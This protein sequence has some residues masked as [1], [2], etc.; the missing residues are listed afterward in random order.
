MKLL[1]E[2]QIRPIV[3]CSS[4]PTEKISDYLCHLLTPHLDNVKS[5]VRNSQQVVQTIESLDL[6]AHPNVT[7]V[8]L[9]VES[10]YLSIPQAAGIEMVLQ[11]VL[12]TSPP[13]A[14]YK[15]LKN[16]A[17][18]LLKIV[19]HDNTFHFHD[20]YY[21]QFGGVAMGTR[22][23][24]PFANLFLGSLEEKA[25]TSW[26]GSHPL[27]WLR[28]LDDVLILWEGDTHELDNFLIHMNN[29]MAAIK[30][31]MSHSQENI[32]FL[33]LDI[34]KGHRFRNT[35]VL[36]IKAYKKPTNP[37]TFLHDE[38]CHALSTFPTIVRGELLRLLR[39]SSD[40]ENYTIAVSKLLERFQ[41]R[42]YPKPLLMAVAGSIKYGDRP[43]YLVSHPK[44]TLQPNVTIFSMR[45]HPAIQSKAIWEI[46]FDPETPFSPMVTRPRPISI[47]DQLVKAKTPGR[48]RVRIERKTDSTQQSQPTPSI[49]QAEPSPLSPPST[50]PLPS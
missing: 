35:G 49:E 38:S 39:A 44:R 28:F 19:I 36:D 10:L 16:F 13:Q 21:N 26:S 31:T 11:R 34:Y 24:P 41:Q 32:T 33:D 40:G 9:D 37:Q 29:Q 50:P 12:P 2:R 25:L 45:Y 6:S 43:D 18:E 30:F 23:A 22:C 20:K 42:G 5:L 1:P 4:G 47:R 3:S 14:T 46:L 8:S 15:A 48:T 27:L 17:R 7:L